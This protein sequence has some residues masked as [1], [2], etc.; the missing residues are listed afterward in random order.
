MFRDAK[1]MGAP[2]RNLLFKIDPSRL[3][4]GLA[5]LANLAV[6]LFKDPAW[7]NPRFLYQP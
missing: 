6:Q 3:F 5:L 7:A 1:K 2:V 4:R